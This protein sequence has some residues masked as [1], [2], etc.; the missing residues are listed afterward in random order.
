VQD[1]LDETIEVTFD[2]TTT[3]ITLLQNQTVIY[4]EV[5]PCTKGIVSGDW[6][7]LQMVSFDRF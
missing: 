2:R 1:I 3:T 7:G 5:G 4:A 6:K